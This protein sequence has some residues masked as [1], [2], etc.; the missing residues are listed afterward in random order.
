MFV[1]SEDQSSMIFR[2]LFDAR[3]STYTYLLADQAGP[4][5]QAEAVLIDTVFEQHLRDAALL[6]ELNLRLVATLETHVHAD[7]VTGAWLMKRAFGSRILLGARSGAEGADELLEDGAVV[8]FGGRSLSLRATPGH[9]DGCVTW[10]LD[11]QRMAFTGDALLIRGAGRTDFQQGD[12]C[13]LYRSVR[14]RIFSLPYDCLLYPG[15][16]YQGRTVTTVAEERQH[17]PRLGIDKAE[18][19]F[20]GTMENLGLAHPAQLAV[21][22]PANLRCGRPQTESGSDE[23]ALPGAVSWGPV[24][25]TYAGIAEVPPLWV[26]GQPEGLCVVDVRSEAEFNGELRHVPGARLIPLGELRV[27]LDELPHDAVLITVCRSG[28]RSAQASLILERAGF[29]RVA[30]LAGGMLRWNAEGLPVG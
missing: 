23:A 27:R 19:D 21:A 3:S 2:Q 5:E 28:A 6:R 16:D 18:A 14:E 17:N 30:N 22:V 8:R 11:D 13:T 9:T 1:T 4:G 7:H 15:H 29:A 20:V 12:A 24:T 26:A 25:R 10:V